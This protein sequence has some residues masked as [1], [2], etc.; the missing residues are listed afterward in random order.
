MQVS[1]HSIQNC[2]WNASFS[3][4]TIQF[5]LSLLS[6]QPVLA[7]QLCSILLLFTSL[8]SQ[9][10]WLAHVFQCCLNN[11]LLNL[12][13]I[14]RRLEWV[15]L[16]STSSQLLSS[17][18]SLTATLL[19]LP[20]DCSSTPFPLAIPLTFFL[21]VNRP[22][23]LVFE[24]QVCLNYLWCLLINSTNYSLRSLT[25]FTAPLLSPH[26]FFSKPLFSL[27]ECLVHRRNDCFSVFCYFGQNPFYTVL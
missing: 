15:L 4:S 21:S 25:S 10:S 5:L 19:I 20:F 12:V 23:H 26:F 8:A 3:N 16:Q 6:K 17:C 2:Q 13:F 1:H 18:P 27:W 24:G 14:K 7:L 9:G 22:T 11:H